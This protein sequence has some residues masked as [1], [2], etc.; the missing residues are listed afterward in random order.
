MVAFKRWHWSLIFLT[1]ILLIASFF[2][3]YR[4]RDY[5]IFLGDEG[6]DALVWKR[7]I[8][9]HKFTLLGP[10][11]SVGGFYLGPVYYYLTLPFA[12]GLKLDPVGPA[13][14]VST[15]GIA[16]VY[17]V[18]LF[19]RRYLNK[20][21]GLIAAFL[22]SFA[23][24]I[25]RYSRSSW[26][27]NPLPFFT[28]AGLMLVYEGV[29][30]KKLWLSFLAGIG[31]GIAWQLHYLALILAP[32]YLAIV[33][34]YRQNLKS[35]IYHLGSVFIG[36]IIGFLPFLAFEIRH[37]F[38]N[39]RT[40]FEFITRPY[41]AIHPQIA[42]VFITS[43]KRTGFMFATVL[44][45]PDTL[46]L[47]LLAMAATLTT[48]VWSLKRHKLLLI[49]C[50]VG[51]FGFAF[52]NTGIADYYFGFLFPVPFLMIAI[53]LYRLCRHFGWPV[54]IAGLLFLSYHQLSK[55]FFWNKP[56]RQIDQTARIA[57][58]VVAQAGGQPFN[59]ALI[60]SGNSDHAYRFFLEIENHRP[61]GLDEKITDQLLIVC[62]KPEPECKPLGNSLWEVA[63]FGRSEVNAQVTV[64]PGITIYR[65]IHYYGE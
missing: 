46:W 45:L 42:D 15:L 64:D 32:I 63:G 56:N 36:W 9:D 14:F 55:A 29:K 25:V 20:T 49:W 47:R 57:G 16:T 50:S 30:Q 26:N 62:E 51:M 65:M 52:Y 41:G 58:I 23:P 7:M 10:T 43:V 21:I 24:L 39:T 6:R 53:L 40:I 12:W 44:M 28:L 1:A 2:R 38:P 37:A 8:I 60:S 35:T 61:L 59:F 54:F 3:L 22:Y 31:L 27:P 19:G 48:I 17:L 4:V 34:V 11:A 18:Y 5:L 13:Y 33:L